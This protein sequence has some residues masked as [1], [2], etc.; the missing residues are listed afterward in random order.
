MIHINNNQKINKARTIQ[1][2]INFWI[3]CTKQYGDLSILHIEGIEWILKCI[4]KSIKEINRLLD[5]AKKYEVYDLLNIEEINSSLI[6]IEQRY[7]LLKG[8]E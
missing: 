6:D 7:N 4:P 5:D 8:S 3:K 1:K 2:E